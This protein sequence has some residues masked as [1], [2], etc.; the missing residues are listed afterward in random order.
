M[1]TVS[2]RASA[3][4]CIETLT[5]MLVL[6][7]LLAGGVLPGV[8]MASAV[9]APPLYP[10]YTQRTD[11]RQ[12]ETAAKAFLE[13][14]RAEG[15]LPVIVGLRFDL[16]A[17]DKLSRSAAYAQSAALEA[18]QGRVASRV[19]ARDPQKVR[20]YS[21]IPFMALTVNE[22]QFGKLLAD[23]DVASIQEDTVYFPQLNDTI[24]LIHVD[25]VLKKFGYSGIGRVIAI[26]DSGV[27]KNH[28]ML[29]GK[30]LSEAC[31]STPKA[32]ENRSSLCPGGVTS[33]T[34]KG[35]GVNCPNDIP[36]CYH[37][38][39]VASIAAGGPVGTLRGVA[40]GAGIIAI[41]VFS[42]V[43]KTN[44]DGSIDKSLS[45]QNADIVSGL[46]RVYSLRKKFK[47][48]AVNMSISGGRYTA[49]C[50][51]SDPAGAASV[52]ALRQAG[53]AVIAG[54][55][56]KGSDTEIGSPACLSGV[57]AVAA[58]T[59]ADETKQIEYVWKGSDLN[60]LVKLIAPGAMVRSAVPGGTSCIT[61]GKPYCVNSGTS[62]ATPH[63]AGAFAVLKGAFPNASNDA[64]LNAL[65]C[66]GKIV[67]QTGDNANPYRLALPRID[68][69]GAYK[70]LKRTQKR[71]WD[72][73]K[74]AQSSDWWPIFGKWKVSDGQYHPNLPANALGSV[75][76]AVS[77]CAHVFDVSA[78]LT[79]KT[80]L[81]GEFDPRPHYG[82]MIDAQ[83]GS[84]SRIASGYMF[85]IT[86]W[87]KD[88]NPA[89]RVQYQI[90]RV[91]SGSS[92]LLAS[93][94]SG[95]PAIFNA[96][97]TVRISSDD[98]SHK[99]YVN[100][101]LVLSAANDG[102]YQSGQVVFYTDFDSSFPTR[103]GT[104]TVDNV[105]ITTKDPPP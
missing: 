83:F 54:S 102:I 75:M 95:G 87:P 76:S 73:S 55:G 67:D 38:T 96:K 97:N 103:F 92:T 64:I 46:D 78:D 4:L 27:A 2:V 91:D 84:L 44:A 98:T 42:V 31:Y 47:I 66:S 45:T 33:S 41:Q 100:G 24:P 13:R 35:S 61:D 65:E 36:L 34:A 99:F 101:Q 68:L 32:S 25:V 8:A 74:A 86:Q 29:A 12:K 77:N 60:S 7:A 104:F 48:A 51:A 71:G 50:D 9:K 11:A 69:L 58:S 28:P 43:S 90:F 56:N 1:A 3:V 88:P 85:L 72:F 53:I 17:E 22:A 23:P 70:W 105:T 82:L 52:A 89:L 62:L 57:I 14:I 49:A 30:V 10:V 59:K 81:G 26:I 79:R 37:G 6:A 39:S 5:A 21:F 40:S 15:S 80:A 18:M 93:T 20:R 63:V 19:L 94:Y 16:Q